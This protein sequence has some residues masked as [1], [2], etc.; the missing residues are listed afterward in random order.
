LLLTF[1]DPLAQVAALDCRKVR[2]RFEERFTAHRMAKDY[3]R[4]YRGLVRHV[5]QP[6]RGDELVNAVASL[7]P[8]CWPDRGTV[9][10]AT[11]APGSQ[12]AVEPAVIAFLNSDQTVRWAKW[13]TL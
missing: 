12:D 3:V 8:I 4:V 13:L 11:F 2:S 6:G 5:A 10:V 9:A 1:G 7:F